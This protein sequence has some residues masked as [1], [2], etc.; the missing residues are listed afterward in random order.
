MTK[1]YQEWV[2]VTSWY[3]GDTFYGVLDLGNRIFLGGGLA[4]ADGHVEVKTIRQRC[5]LIQAAEEKTPGGP[6]ARD[7]AAQLA[8]PGLYP[9]VTYKAPEEYGRPLIDLILPAGRFSDL[10]LA[11]K[12]AVPYA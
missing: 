11:A 2:A 8:P 7:Y 5:A 6:T 4:V 10:M 9:C 12:M 1:T 3:D